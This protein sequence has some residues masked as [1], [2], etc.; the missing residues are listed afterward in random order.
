MKIAFAVVLILTIIGNIFAKNDKNHDHKT[1]AH[2]DDPHKKPARRLLSRKLYRKL[3]GSSQDKDK[4]KS[5]KNDFDVQFDSIANASSSKFNTA[6]QTMAIGKGQT[7][8]SSSIGK[9]GTINNLQ[10]AKGGQASQSFQQIGE[11]KASS[12]Q[13]K[14]DKNGEA[15]QVT[16]ASNNQYNL[17][18]ANQNAFAGKGC[19]S[20]ST[21]KDGVI[22]AVEGSEGAA[23]ADSWNKIEKNKASSNQVA[24][25]ASA[26]NCKKVPVK[27]PSKKYP[28]KKAPIKACNKPVQQD[29]DS[30]SSDESSQS[31]NSS[32][33]SAQSS[34]SSDESAQSS[35][36]SD[37]S[38]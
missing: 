32:D 17:Q 38:K 20:S 29:E 25:S 21:G 15:S 7:S 5:D 1:Q 37:C 2:N 16:V 19:S 8:I 34:N 9:A 6:G 27:A 14:K 11:N 3:N 30:D 18:G 33:E 23:N 28:A 36:S 26:K 22:S 31:S 13:T 24:V 12:S 35:T 4:I 10:A